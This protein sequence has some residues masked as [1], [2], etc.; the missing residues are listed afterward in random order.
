MG[1]QAC[2]HGPGVKNYFIPNVLKM[3]FDV[4]LWKTEHAQTRG[5]FLFIVYDLIGQISN[6]KPDVHG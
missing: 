5:N 1:N 4:F 3:N 6:G 2:T